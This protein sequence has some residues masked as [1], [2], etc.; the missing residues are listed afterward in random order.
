MDKRKQK[1]T[2]SGSAKQIRE[3]SIGWMIKTIG[4]RLD[5]EMGQSLK[6]HGLSL[7]QFGILMTLFE[8]DDLTQS[9]IGKKISMPGYAT[10]RNLDTLEEMKLLKRH[11]DTSSRRSF[12]IRLTPKGRALAPTLFS[13]VQDVNANLTTLLSASET[14]QLT[15]LLRKII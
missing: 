14:K 15:G 13:I 11:T 3:N 4:T 1:R 6:E 8:K 7:S 12:R 10:T 5:Q 9:Q 2:D